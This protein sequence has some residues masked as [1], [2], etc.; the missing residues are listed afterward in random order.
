MTRRTTCCFTGHRPGRLP[1]G[2]CETDPRCLA[3]KGQIAEAVARTYAEGYRHFICGMAQGTDQYFC[4]AVLALRKTHPDLTVEAAVPF[5][6]Q[7][8]RWPAAA[9][10][11]YQAL[12]NQCNFETVIQHHYTAGC[13]NRRNRYM[14]DHASFLIAAYDGQASG[15]TRSTLAYAMRQELAVLVL[16]IPPLARPF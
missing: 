13:M 2:D 10:R 15:G 11:R 6:G 4:E 12:L 14:V 7:A 8:D 3:L 16:E 1:W 9:R 5:A